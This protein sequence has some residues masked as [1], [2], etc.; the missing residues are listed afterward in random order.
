ML[1]GDDCSNIVRSVTVRLKPAGRQHRERALQ[2][3]AD[4]FELCAESGV[5]QNKPCGVFEHAQRLARTIGVGIHGTRDRFHP[6]SVAAWLS[7]TSHG[8]R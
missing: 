7:F 1:A 3:V 4:F 2:T 8:K 6:Q 5:V